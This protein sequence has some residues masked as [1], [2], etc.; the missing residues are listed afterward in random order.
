MYDRCLLA[1]R[2]ISLLGFLVMCLV[3]AS[4]GQASPEIRTQ[5]V[6]LFD[7]QDWLGF[8][9][10]VGWDDPYLV[11][12]RA[13]AR[14]VILLK[15]SDSG[16]IVLDLVSDA[17]P[18]I[19]FFAGRIAVNHDWIFVSNRGHNSGNGKVAIFQRV[20]ETLVRR[21]QLFS[22][23]PGLAVFG[24]ALASAGDWLVIG[25]TRQDDDAGAAHVY[26][27]QGQDWVHY[28]ELHSSIPGIEEFGA[29]CAISESG[30]M[31]VGQSESAT[32]NL[33]VYDLVNGWW[34]LDEVIEDPN[35]L[36]PYGNVDRFGE[37]VDISADGRVIVAGDRHG[38]RSILSGGGFFAGEAFVF[39]NTLQSGTDSWMQV[40]SLRASNDFGHIAGVTA[41]FGQTVAIHGDTVVVGAPRGLG[42]ENTMQSA[43][44]GYRRGADGTWPGFEDFRLLR[45]PGIPAAMG[46]S[47]EFDG[48]TVFSGAD[49]GTSG[50]C[51]FELG[52]EVVRCEGLSGADVNVLLD[53]VTSN[54]TVAVHG[55]VPHSS[56][57]LFGALLGAGTSIVPSPSTGICLPIDA[58][59]VG[60]PRSAGQ[61]GSVYF[62]GLSAPRLAGCSSVLCGESI[63]LQPI[64]APAPGV[65]FLATQA[66]TIEL[67]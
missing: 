13:Q 28:Q 3:S 33:H 57:R 55:L 58:F 23:A 17:T 47:L 66:V 49:V 41:N 54:L 20:G 1:A 61:G 10:D 51:I 53:P 29:A 9:S 22:P 44:Y 7:S 24:E 19:S 65:R 26:Q 21:G 5:D 8:G 56:I 2:Q 46:R 59:E 31:V 18:D 40:G 14:Q 15:R 42:L 38:E 27:R 30:V 12:A 37:A 11:V 25:S 45:D 4:L 35:D 62:T 6:I 43:V 52:Q 16:W 48:S 67:E 60:M 39:E 50:L 36:S 32:G 64:V 34:T 63:I